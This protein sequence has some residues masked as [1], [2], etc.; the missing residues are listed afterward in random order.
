M[1]GRRGGRGRG[2]SRWDG[3]F[4]LSCA[5]RWARRKRVRYGGVMTGVSGI[6]VEIGVGGFRMA[7]DFNWERKG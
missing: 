3:M 6:L 2:C 7:R 1:W 5:M 4:S